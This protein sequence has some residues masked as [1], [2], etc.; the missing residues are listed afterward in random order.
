MSLSPMFQY[1]PKWEA[2]IVWLDPVAKESLFVRET[3][4]KFARR[5]GAPPRRM[6]HYVAYATLQAHAP[7]ISPGVFERRVWYLQP[8]DPS[9][10]P[11]QAVDPHSIA[12]DQS[13]KRGKRED[14]R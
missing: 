6:R 3:T 1:D 7:S 14:A 11:I 10:Y 5:A 9:G 12:A 4:A 8:H 2:G 13:S